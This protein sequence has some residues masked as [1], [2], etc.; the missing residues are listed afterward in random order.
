M[1]KGGNRSRKTPQILNCL[2]YI[3]ISTHITMNPP[4]RNPLD[5]AKY[6]EQYLSSLR[7][8]A[9]ND[10][11]NLDAN[12][13]FKLTGQSPQPPP[14]TRGTTE[15][16]MDFEGQKVA[17]RSRLQTITDGVI[18][19][20]IVAELSFPQVRF[21][22]DKW[23]I[24]SEDMKK[25][26][27]TGLPSSVFIAYLNRLIE[28]FESA[29]A[30][31]QGLQQNIGEAIIMSNIQLLYGLPRG[32]IWSVLKSSIN[33]AESQF[34][35]DLIDLK[36]QVRRQQ[37]LVPSEEDLQAVNGLP[38]PQRARVQD[39]L[40]R[41]FE[42]FPTTDDLVNQV[43]QINVGISNRDRN[44]TVGALG[45]LEQLVTVPESSMV[46]AQE[47]QDI[48]AR[49]VGGEPP[50]GPDPPE[51]PENFDFPAVPTPAERGG[52]PP[53]P[54]DFNAPQPP[55]QGPAPAFVQIVDRAD[56]NA[57][58]S[59]ARKAEYLNSVYETYPFISLKF[60]SKSG[61]ETLRFKSPS[62]LNPNTY[63]TAQLNEMFD[64]SLSDIET[65]RVRPP[66]GSGMRMKGKGLNKPYRQSIKHLIDK[67]VEKPKLY[68]PFGKYLIN[69]HRLNHE[70]VIAL[71][72]Q[73]GNMIQGLGTEKV[74]P[75]LAKV[76]RTLVGKGLPSYEDIQ[77]LSQ[78]DKRKL[79]HICKSSNIESPAIPHMK[80]EGQA[81]EDRFNIL[82]GEIIAGNDSQK[83]ARE[84]KIILLKFI[85]EGRI[86]RQQGNEILREMLSL[87]V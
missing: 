57:L 62:P 17:L 66:T 30:V 56:W 38:A 44:F 36:E 64:N 40:D 85:Q 32:Q 74:S 82:R 24:I 46:H 58:A 53:E 80:G 10:Q 83:V 71:R 25:Q 70:D 9:S 13:V 77:G 33:R 84:F 75:A 12:K 76:V 27:A 60:T 49:F 5:S 1:D 14:D 48:M 35:L 78:D 61:R 47:I 3:I 16:A 65:M 52:G 6:R 86:P 41:I 8:Q 28:K 87:G 79:S 63:T 55:Q 54:P 4:C 67:P 22:L 31:Q 18:A 23:A 19:S 68:T 81:E 72:H 11:R 39:L 26:F 29:D 50:R 34:R 21:A 59:K 7:L 20:Q 51:V 45:D 2:V 15:K 43:G 42:T 69:K 73:S 37:I